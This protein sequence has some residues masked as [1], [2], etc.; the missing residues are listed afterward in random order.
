MKKEAEEKEAERLRLE[1][2]ERERQEKLAQRTRVFTAGTYIVGTDIEPGTYNMIAVSG[3]GNCYVESTS[4]VIETFTPGGD[5]WAIDN[6]KN[7]ILSSGGTIEVTST[8]QI[9][10]EAVR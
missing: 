5:R 4:R 1:Q 9:K 8:L 2:E 10:F 3:R 6:Y 7:V